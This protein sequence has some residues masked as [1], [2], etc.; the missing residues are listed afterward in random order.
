MLINYYSLEGN[1]VVFITF[2]NICTFWQKNATSR[3]YY[4]KVSLL[5]G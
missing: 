2:K 5:T 3:I 1:L 4:I